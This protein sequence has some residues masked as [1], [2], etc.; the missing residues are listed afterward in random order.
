M[1]IDLLRD[2]AANEIGWGA[3]LERMHAAQQ[4]FLREAALA[5]AEKHLLAKG[6]LE[7]LEHALMLID[8]TRQEIRRTKG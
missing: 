4:T 2:F 8:H 1:S 7:G 3:V 6:R 5:D